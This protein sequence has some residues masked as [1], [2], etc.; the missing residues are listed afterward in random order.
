MGQLFPSVFQTD[1][2]RLI[3]PFVGGAA[4]FFHLQPRR[5]WLNDINDELVNTY[6]QL[7]NDWIP[8]HKLLQEY[9]LEHTKSFYYAMRDTLPQGGVERAARFIYLNRTCFNGIY[10]VNLDGRFNVPKGSKSAVVMPEDN[11]AAIANALRRVRLTSLD[12]EPVIDECGSC[13]L[14]FVDP[15]YTVL[16]NFNGFV[17][18]NENLF[19]WADQ[20]RLRDALFRARH[21]G[22][23]VIVSNADHESVRQLYSESR[24]VHR[25]ERP[26]VIAASAEKRKRTTEL[27][28][29]L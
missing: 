6:E 11:F 18:Y 28:I 13:D 17:K 15:P 1:F 20:V 12:F 25:I 4:V 21:R 19:S 2:A 26:S 7:K 16:H 3:E 29:S 14:L 8:V 22:A 24:Y 9:H 10:R 27:L 23:K 5:A